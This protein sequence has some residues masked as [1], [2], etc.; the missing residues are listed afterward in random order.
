MT[1]HDKYKKRHQHSAPHGNLLFVQEDIHSTA[2]EP[3]R[4]KNAEIWRD[5]AKSP[6]LQVREWSAS[7]RAC[8]DLPFDRIP[9]FAVNRGERQSQNATLNEAP[10]VRERAGILQRFGRSLFNYFFS[11]FRRI[12]R[13]LKNNANICPRCLAEGT[14]NRTLKRE[15]D[16]ASIDCVDCAKCRYRFPASYLELPRV[17]FATGGFKSAGKTMWLLTAF[18][19][20][21]ATDIP[22]W[23]SLVSD[24]QMSPEI[25]HVLT[26]LRQ[27]VQPPATRPY[28]IGEP[29]TLALW[30]ASRRPKLSLVSV[31][32]FAGEV[33]DRNIY[34]DQFR[35]RS[36]LMDGFLLFLDPTQL[37][38][39]F[40]GSRDSLLDRQKDQVSNFYLDLCKVHGLEGNDV[41]RV[42]VAVCVS[43]FDLLVSYNPIGEMARRKCAELRAMRPEKNLTRDLLRRRSE[44]CKSMLPV[45]FQGWDV[46]D[47]MR[48]RFGEN[49][50]YFPMSSVGLIDSELGEMDTRKWTFSPFGTLEPLLWLLHMNGRKIFED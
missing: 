43:K 7:L 44:L 36:L 17:C 9:A 13:G 2:N 24:M 39:D 18:D 23:A 40:R 6:D 47:V 22:V 45:L 27:R 20:I 49:V 50:M 21:L 48:K 14:L 28:E 42:P 12:R 31:F 15:T 29:I 10:A 1:L 30:E 16:G 33:M 3:E 5:L 34:D 35:Q 32:D 26:L 37:E 8:L 19:Q 4:G 25:E 41:V 11:Y 46:A 38:S